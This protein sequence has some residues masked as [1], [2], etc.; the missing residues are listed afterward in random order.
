MR[1]RGKGSAKMTSDHFGQLT[2]LLVAGAG[3]L[4]VGGLNLLL[5]RQAVAVRALATVFVCGIA[6]TGV[7]AVGSD[8]NVVRDASVILAVGTGACLLAQSRIVASAGT[9]MVSTVRR[10]AVGGGV[11][12]VAGFAT[13]IGSLVRYELQDQAEI[14]RSMVEMEMMSAPPPAMSPNT[15]VARTDHGTPVVL[16]EATVLRPD[17]ELGTIEQLMLRKESVR[18]TVIRTHAA[19]DRSNCHGWVF[20][21]GRFWVLGNAV[22]QI[23]AENGYQPVTAPR[24]GDVAIFRAGSTVMHTAVVR[25]VTVGQPV[26]VEGKWGCTGVYLHPVDKSLY[27]TAFTYYRSPRTGHLLAGL[28]ASASPV[29]SEHAP[30]VQQ[31]LASSNKFTD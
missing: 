3:M 15:T 24:P 27:G 9:A 8:I 1:V 26:L 11:L 4:A 20:A 18:D 22:D 21:G 25:Y 2:A 23:L 17:A 10:P 29:P 31:N 5:R 13:V 30:A 7:W 28:D 14:D 19:D 12:A 6:V 16:Q